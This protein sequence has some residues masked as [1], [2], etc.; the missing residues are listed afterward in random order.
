MKEKISR[1]LRRNETGASM[2]EYALL[3]VLIAVVA[4]VAVNLV[5]PEVSNAFSSTAD[6]FSAN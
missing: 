1:A 5:G 2:V 4:F 3:L 6:G